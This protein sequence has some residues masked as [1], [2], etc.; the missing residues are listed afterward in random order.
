MGLN[1]TYLEVYQSIWPPTKIA[2]CP[3]TN[4]QSPCQYPISS[5]HHLHHKN[6]NFSSNLGAKFA[7]TQNICYC[8]SKALPNKM[9]GT[10]VYKK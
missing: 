8:S 10:Y 6:P 2:S 5:W 7:H 3:P 4:S 1:S 9:G